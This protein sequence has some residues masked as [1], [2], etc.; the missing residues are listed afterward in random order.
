[1][2]GGGCRGLRRSLRGRGGGDG[3]GEAEAV[4]EGKTA[5][6]EGILEAYGEIDNEEFRRRFIQW[7]EL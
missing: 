1:M 7:E 3:G 4:G 2:R 5:T 6:A